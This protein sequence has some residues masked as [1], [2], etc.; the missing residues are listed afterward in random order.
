VGLRVDRSNSAGS[1]GPTREAILAAL[2]DVQDPEA[3]ISIVDLGLVANCG[4]SQDGAIEV[5]LLPTRSGC[6]AREFIRFLVTKRLRVAFGDRQVRCRWLGADAW[7]TDRI[8]E[9]GR[10]Q[11]REYG[12]AVPE[13]RPDGRRRVRCPYCESTRVRR[14]SAFGASVCRALWYCNSCRTPFEE[15][16]WLSGNADIA[17]QSLTEVKPWTSR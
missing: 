3:P 13:L 12:I 17:G 6:P 7:S 14:E 10:R 4:L 5:D 8:T 9:R 11:L 15:M 2:Q 16:R 1:A